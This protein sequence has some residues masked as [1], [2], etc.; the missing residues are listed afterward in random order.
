MQLT[1]DGFANIAGILREL[2]DELCQGRLLFTLE[3][4]YN[5]QALSQ[6]IRATLEV[7]LGTPVTPDPVGKPRE[8]GRQINLDS[9]YADIASRH[10]LG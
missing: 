7:L 1:V 2:A 3:G 4:G 10:S 5:L 6:G 8:A 9:L